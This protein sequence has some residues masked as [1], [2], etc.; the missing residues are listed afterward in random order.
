MFPKYLQ[1]F[2]IFTLQYSQNRLTFCINTDD[3]NVAL[4]PEV[5]NQWCEFGAGLCV[6]QNNGRW[7]SLEGSITSE[8]LAAQ[9][10]PT[11]ISKVQTHSQSVR[12]RLYPLT[13]WT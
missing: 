3:V 10:M 13:F 11:N 1:T 2:G 6:W 7:V 8:T 4:L 5:L 9:K 12:A